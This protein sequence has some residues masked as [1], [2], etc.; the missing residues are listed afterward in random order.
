MLQNSILW[1]SLLN[2]SGVHKHLGF[3]TFFHITNQLSWTSLYRSPNSWENFSGV[4]HIAKTRIAGYRGSVLH[5]PVWVTLLSKRS[6]PSLTSTLVQNYFL[7][8]LAIHDIMKFNFF[9][10]DG[11]EMVS[12]AF[13]R[14]LV[15]LCLIWLCLCIVLSLASVACAHRLHF[16]F[17]ILITLTCI[18]MII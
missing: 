14:L 4:G 2:Y 16:V 9:L 5:L 10:S 1:P 18:Y 8:F 13:P 6:A 3:S 15:R 17:K 7:F 12:F 11:C